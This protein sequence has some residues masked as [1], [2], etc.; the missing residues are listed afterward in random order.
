MGETWRGSRTLSPRR[1]ASRPRRSTWPFGGS[2]T[3][4]GASTPIPRM[5]RTLTVPG[6]TRKLDAQEAIDRLV[7]N[8][9]RMRALIE[10]AELNS[11]I[12]SL[13][14]RAR[15]EAELTQAQLARRIGTS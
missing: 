8:D 12:A 5:W 13:V 11:E 10:A 7:G 3:P 4:S 9:S 15:T 2:A 1:T 14:Y 6:K